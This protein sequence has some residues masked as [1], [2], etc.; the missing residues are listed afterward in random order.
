MLIIII[1]DT[2]I[3][4][5]R[6]NKMLL[7]NICFEINIYISSLNKCIICQNKRDRFFIRKII[8]IYYI[9][10]TIIIIKIG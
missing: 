3:K 8:E 7:S 4:V 5:D 9:I 2:S 6:N 1:K 10:R